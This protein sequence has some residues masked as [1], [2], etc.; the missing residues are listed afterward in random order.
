MERQN[1][2][3]DKLSKLIYLDYG[4]F[5]LLMDLLE[6]GGCRTKKIGYEAEADLE[7]VNWI[8]ILHIIWLLRCFRMMLMSFCF[9]GSS[10]KFLLVVNHVHGQCSWMWILLL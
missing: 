8:T 4:G 6:Q 5:F 7:R 1:L 2:S 10:F 9:W 3:S